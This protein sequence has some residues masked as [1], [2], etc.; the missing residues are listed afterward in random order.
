VALSV[1]NAILQWRRPSLAPV[2]RVFDLPRRRPSS[3]PTFLNAVGWSSRPVLA[4]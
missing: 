2:F 4:S 3:A 1:L